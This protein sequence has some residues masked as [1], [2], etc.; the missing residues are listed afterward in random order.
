MHYI[1]THIC[2]LYIFTVKAMWLIYITTTYLYSYKDNWNLIIRFFAIFALH[3]RYYFSSN[4]SSNISAVLSIT[5]SCS[6]NLINKNCYLRFS[7]LIVSSINRLKHYFFSTM[8]DF[9]FILPN[10]RQILLEQFSHC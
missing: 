9:R 6:K 4:N 3:L 10:L 1:Y 2:I 7:S 8:I 5:T